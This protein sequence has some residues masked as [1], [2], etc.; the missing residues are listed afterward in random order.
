MLTF[1]SMITQG[2]KCSKGYLETNGISKIF[3]QTRTP[4][5][6]IHS[7]IAIRQNSSESSPEPKTSLYS[8]LSGKSQGDNKNLKT[9]QM[10]K[11]TEKQR[12][13]RTVEETDLLTRQAELLVD[14]PK[15]ADTQFASKVGCYFCFK[16]REFHSEPEF[17]AL[18]APL[19][20]KYLSPLGRILP[21]NLTNNCSKHQRK[22]ARAIK[23]ARHIGLISYKQ[24]EFV[25]YNPFPLGSITRNELEEMSN[26]PKGPIFSRTRIRDDFA[27]GTEQ[28]EASQ[29]Q[30]AQQTQNVNKTL[31]EGLQ[32]LGKK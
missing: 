11:F 22:V 8:M 27:S 21:K 15:A 13:E 23:K 16:K 30:S 7:C 14:G 29:S 1:G 3:A 10:Q 20:A 19:W 6:P 4:Y 31:L 25:M 5:N 17:D 9:V 18:N 12:M 2:I 32:A 26:E 24:S 28:A